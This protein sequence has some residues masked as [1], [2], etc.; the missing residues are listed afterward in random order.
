M[1]RVA[2]ARSS[3]DKGA[4]RRRRRERGGA[5]VPEEHRA[6][7]HDQR[8]RR[9]LLQG[10]GQRAAH[11]PLT[12]VGQLGRPASASRGQRLSKRSPTIGAATGAPR[13]RSWGS[14]ATT[15]G[16]TTLDAYLG[17]D[18]SGVIELL[19]DL[20]RARMP[21]WLVHRGG[22]RAV[23]ELAI[24]LLFAMG[25]CSDVAK[26]ALVIAHYA[27]PVPPFMLARPTGVNRGG[28]RRVRRLRLRDARG[29]A[30]PGTAPCSVRCWR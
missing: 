15:V 29:I 16:S 12:T 6:L 18:T 10:L 21:H 20:R 30:R 1:P 17:R 9:D 26:A 11:R 3:E 25:A 4:I 22:E 8:P 2:R 24:G 13:A 14:T 23:S 7:H 27:T 5:H 28:R 19:L